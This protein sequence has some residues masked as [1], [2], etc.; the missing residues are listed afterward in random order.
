MRILIADSDKAF[1][2]LVWRYLLRHGYDTKAASDGGEC[3]DVLCD[4]LP[5]VLVLDCGLLW[6][7][8][9]GVNTRMCEHLGL[10]Q[11]P[12]ILIADEDPR[13]KFTDSV[14]PM[15][16]WWLQKPF[17]L[18]ELLN[19]IETNTARCGSESMIKNHRG[20]R[21]IREEIDDGYG[22]GDGPSLPDREAGE[23]DRASSQS[24]FST[25][26]TLK[27]VVSSEIPSKT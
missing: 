25:T 3:A 9:K 4:F 8:S 23:E 12:T 26:T 21:T 27:K 22:E 20:V 16:C 1:L 24:M 14:N 5:D 11:T 10:S 15:L 17:R 2:D 19:C 6:G 18:S 13:D 7:G